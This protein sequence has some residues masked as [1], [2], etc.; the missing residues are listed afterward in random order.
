M[1][2]GWGLALLQKIIFIHKL[3]K[4]MESTKDKKC[5]KCESGEII[6]TGD[7]GPF[8]GLPTN[9]LPSTPTYYRCA[10]CGELFS[11]K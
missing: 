9:P 11:I 1:L 8:D 2:L 3:Y 7:R 6:D 4:N 5:P 10:K